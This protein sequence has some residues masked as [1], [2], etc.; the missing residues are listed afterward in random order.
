MPR[1]GADFGS[2]APLPK[3][4]G[5]YLRM[6]RAWHLQA[7]EAGDR[8]PGLYASQL[9]DNAASDRLEPLLANAAT[10][11]EAVRTFPRF[12]QVYHTG[13]ASR[14]G[15]TPEAW[16]VAFALHDD[17]KPSPFL[18]VFV[19]GTW[20][21]RL[22]RAA[23]GRLAVQEVRVRRG[24]PANTAPYLDVFG[25]NIRWGTREDALYPPT[26]ASSLPI[27]GATSAL[28]RILEREA[29]QT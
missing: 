27:A 6:V 28:R 12:Q 29:A 26:E 2:A 14:S 20:L 11:G 7:R 18:T 16:V 22:R 8:S 25:P 5:V 13:N 9:V 23:G 4:A 1:E 15:V 24:R 17:A 19:L 10:L 21:R 3:D